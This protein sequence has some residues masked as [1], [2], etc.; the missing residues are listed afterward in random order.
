ML[1]FLK[2]DRV[3]AGLGLVGLGVLWTLGN[4][5]RIDL[6]Q[7]LRFFFPALLVVW[8]VLELIVSFARRVS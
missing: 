5:E 3:V 7:A 6:L 8:G 1:S 2:V 4:F